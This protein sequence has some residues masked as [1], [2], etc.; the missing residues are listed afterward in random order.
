VPYPETA[1]LSYRLDGNGPNIG[2]SLLRQILLLGLTCR[3]A[4]L[5]K[6][7]N[8]ALGKRYSCCSRCFQCPLLSERFSLRFLFPSLL[9]VQYPV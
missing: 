5:E 2:F 4:R 3:S 7:S 1:L 8:F 6:L 9:C